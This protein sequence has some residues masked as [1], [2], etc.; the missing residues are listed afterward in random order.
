MKRVLIIHGWG[1]ER[2][3]GHWHRMLATALRKDGY[4]VTAKTDLAVD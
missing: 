3:E 2:P 1:N 4:L